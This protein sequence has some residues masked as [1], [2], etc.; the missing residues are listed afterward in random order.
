MYNTNGWTDGR[1]IDRQT[2]NPK[3]VLSLCSWRSFYIAITLRLEKLQSGLIMTKT[4]NNTMTPLVFVHHL[5]VCCNQCEVNEIT[6]LN[7]Q[8]LIT[9]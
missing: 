5:P 7:A 9:P 3:T 8:M 1:Q 6:K 2:N 4:V